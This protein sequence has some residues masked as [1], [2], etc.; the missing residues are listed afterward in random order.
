MNSM[1]ASDENDVG[2]QRRSKDAAASDTAAVP[3][4]VSP[5]LARSI[6]A[7]E[8][9]WHGMAQEF[10]LLDGTQVA[11]LLGGAGDIDGLPSSVTRGIL[12]VERG[13]EIVYPGFQFD[14]DARTVLP[15]MEPL[16]ALAEAN[17]WRF[18]DVALWL[19]SPSTS[20]DMEDRPV[21]HL[22]SEPSAVLASARDSFE[23]S[24]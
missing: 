18:G 22:I 17:G 9:A 16:L 7:T 6:R 5:Q 13:D 8:V 10:G 23:F 3:A 12:A 19:I 20:F 2:G 4:A 21:D 1:D 14:R 11:I 24:G 15:V